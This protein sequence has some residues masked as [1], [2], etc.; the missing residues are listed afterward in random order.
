MDELFGNVAAKLADFPDMG[1]LGNVP[2]T[3]ELIP[4][5][6]YRLVS[7]RRKLRMGTGVGSHGQDVASLT[8]LN[9]RKAGGKQWELNSFLWLAITRR[10]RLF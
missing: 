7:D 6:N 1:K 9:R 5:E 8:G 2:G 3:R 4:H 10:L